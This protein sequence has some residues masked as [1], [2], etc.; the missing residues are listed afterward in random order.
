MIPERDVGEECKERPLCGTTLGFPFAFVVRLGS[1]RGEGSKAVGLDLFD[2][3]CLACLWEIEF[4]IIVDIGFKDEWNFLEVFD[5]DGVG[6]S[7]L[8]VCFA[9]MAV[10]HRGIVGVILLLHSGR[11]HQH[12]IGHV[13]DL[14]ECSVLDL[15]V[16]FHGIEVLYLTS[17]IGCGVIEKRTSTKFSP[18]E[19]LR[20][21]IAHIVVTRRNHRLDILLGLPIVVGH[22]LVV[23]QEVKPV[24]ATGGC[25]YSNYR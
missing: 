25:Q 18:K 4:G 9:E 11:I 12:R 14:V 8:E 17:L 6:K 7:T 20:N 5:K 24:V 23:G 1:T 10:E 2:N 13:D 16:A 21:G 15:R 19:H 3:L 22:L